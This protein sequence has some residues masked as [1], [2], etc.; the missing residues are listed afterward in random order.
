MMERTIIDSWARYEGG[1]FGHDKKT[2]VEGQLCLTDQ[3][4]VFNMLHYWRIRHPLE[5][6]FTIPVERLIH[7]QSF[8]YTEVHR[9]K[10]IYAYR[11]G[12]ILV[13]CTDERD[14]RNTLVFDVGYHPSDEIWQD[15]V[16]G[17]IAFT[18][19]GRAKRVSEVPI[20]L[21]KNVEAGYYGVREPMTYRTVS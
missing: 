19:Q 7:C 13:L 2:P 9:G 12:K 21:V 8:A 5:L 6:C 14:V 3:R 11:R 10:F 1:Y 4:L 16:N 18:K 17:A 20:W 15:K